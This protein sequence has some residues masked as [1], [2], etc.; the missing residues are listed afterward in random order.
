MIEK[1]ILLGWSGGLFLR[2]AG[3]ICRQAMQYRCR[4]EL[5]IGEKHY[6][7]RSVLSVLSAQ[8]S[9]RGDALLC[10]D[11]IDE[12]DAASALA[13]LLEESLEKRQTE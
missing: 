13:G 5:V 3:E 9:T 11:G 10:C 12:L 1:K 7:L 4:S 6:N 8:M 2:P